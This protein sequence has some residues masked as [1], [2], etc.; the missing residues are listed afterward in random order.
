MPPLACAQTSQV[1]TKWA[2]KGNTLA[3]PACL[4]ACMER[5]LAATATPADENK[6]YDREGAREAWMNGEG[7]RCL[8]ASSDVYIISEALMGPNAE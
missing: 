8:P 3:G 1:R 5:T 2:I 6:V 4:F 7:R